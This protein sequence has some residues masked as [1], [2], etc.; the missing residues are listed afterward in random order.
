MLLSR[1][2]G[3]FLVFMGLIEKYGTDRESVTLQ[4]LNQKAASEYLLAIQQ[5]QTEGGVRLAK[6]HSAHSVDLEEER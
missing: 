2:C 4:T 1:F 6:L 5:L 3:T